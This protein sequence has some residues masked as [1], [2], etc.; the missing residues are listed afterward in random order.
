M[1]CPLDDVLKKKQ[2]LLKS[3]VDLQMIVIWPWLEQSYV[4]TSYL[5]DIEE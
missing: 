1:F 2:I 5:E 4:N 3:D